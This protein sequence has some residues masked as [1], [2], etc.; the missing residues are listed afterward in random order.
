MSK[1]MILI[2]GVLLML[3]LTACSEKKEL[4]DGYGNF[5]AKEII[6][7]AKS[8]GEIVNFH[9]EEGMKLETGQQIGIID[10]TMLALKKEQLI[11]QIKGFRIKVESGR[12]KIKG[13]ERKIEL[14]AK[15]KTRIIGLFRDNATT[16]QNRDRIVAEY[17]I[18]EINK[19]VAEEDIKSLDY[20]IEALEKQIAQLNES[21][22]NCKIINPIAGT[23]LEKYLEENELA[24]PGRPLY[25][26]ADLRKMILRVY[27]SGSQLSNI[28][29]GQN[30]E[31][32]IDLNNTQNQSLSGKISWISSSAEF[33]PKN[34]QTKEE[35]VSQVYAVKIL[36]N[37]EDG[38]LKI[39]MPG[40][41]DLLN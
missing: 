1:N 11:A 13:I 12:K 20:Q 41:V 40:E 14:L 30:V 26:I 9:I 33:T 31:V 38:K 24:A 10:T 25:K 22:D 3:M 4:S 8:Q 28:K 27:I 39:G 23:V 34:I 6:I 17:D 35:R 7:S 2:F 5:E 36:V 19:K 18:A 15:E 16:E 21:L 37:N 32:L 29:I